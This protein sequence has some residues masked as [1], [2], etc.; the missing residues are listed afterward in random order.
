[1]ALVIALSSLVVLVQKLTPGRS[2]CC[3]SV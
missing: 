1:M 2:R 3:V